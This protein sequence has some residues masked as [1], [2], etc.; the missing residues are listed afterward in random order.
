MNTSSLR[1]NAQIAL[2]VIAVLAA[3]GSGVRYLA[4]GGSLFADHVV[5]TPG[6]GPVGL[7]PAFEFEGY[8]G[9]R[10]VSVFLCLSASGD[11]EGCADLGKG[12]AGERLIGK[13]IPA[14]LP[15]GTTVEPGTFV[16]R[17]GPEDDDTYPERGEFEVVPFRVGTKARAQ[18]FEGV[19]AADLQAG[20]P[21]RIARGVA[22]RPPIFLADGRLSVG[23]TIFDPVTN[24]T[25][26]FDIDAQEL[27]WSPVG[28]KLAILTPDRKEIRLAAPD[29][30][31]AVTRV[32]EARGF[33][34]SL[35]WSPDG[36]H[37]AYIAAPDPA[38][39]QL[40]GD[41]RS[42]TVTILNATNGNR[43]TAGP[44]LSVAWSP[45]S[46]VLAVEMA[47]G[48]I[49]S[50]TPS[51]SRKPLATGSKPSWS[52]DGRFLSVVR[53]EGEQQRA[54][55]VPASGGSGVAITGPGGCA[56]S[57]SPTG[58]ALSV[59]AN[60]NGQTSLQVRTLEIEGRVADDA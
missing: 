18:S 41:P 29:G 57:F 27:A 8:P 49:E 6:A 55:I 9:G 37:L 40:A 28:D 51:G 32:R 2:A 14:E 10:E 45:D 59:V 19:T 38:T 20:D 42:P 44:G 48:K 24:V 50:S 11:I 13:P 15:D 46:D 25:I 4:R 3:I 60:Q 35:S 56:M 17:A 52:H 54:W 47:G 22:C 53:T 36:A 12:K 5:A 31:S 21:R 30:S 16:I 39:R 23:S 34:S 1:R 43:T 33:I 7:R 26:E 58:R